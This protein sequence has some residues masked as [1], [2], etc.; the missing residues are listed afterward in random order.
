MSNVAHSSSPDPLRRQLQEQR[1]WPRRPCGTEMKAFVVVAEN[2]A[3][4]PATVRNISP[5]GISLTLEQNAE[6][7][8]S[9]LLDLHNDA[10]GFRCQ[11]PAKVVYIVDLPTGDVLHGCKFARALSA[12]EV[13]GLLA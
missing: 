4:W 11:V 9:V 5:G 13:R 6:P 3:P 10:N 2:V 12:L 7:E 1:R 8:R